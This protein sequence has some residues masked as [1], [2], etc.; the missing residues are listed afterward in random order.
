MF[1][2]PQTV[3]WSMQRLHC[4]T[5]RA[6]CGLAISV[7]LSLSSAQAAES[8]E[9]LSQVRFQTTYVW[10]RKPG[11]S[12]AYSGENSLRPEL[13]K[14]SFTLTTT[15]FL[16]VRTWQ[17][18]EL[19]FN[20]EMS[21]S[22]ALSNLHGLG[23]LTNGENQKGSSPSPIFYVGRLFGR[24]TWNLGGGSDS[25]ESAPNQLAGPVDKHR[26]ILTAGKLSLTDI[27]DN[28]SFSH[29]P[30]TQFL[31][32]AIMTHG[33]FDYA[34]DQ[35][36]YTVGAALEYYR[37]DL[38]FRFGRFQ[39]PIESN[40]LALDSQ[41]MNHYG[42]QLEIER[43][44]E[45]GG[46]P[47]KFRLLAFRN[48]ASMGSFRDAIDYWNSQG[49]TGVPAVS[50]VR[51]NQIK[52]GYGASIEQNLSADAGIFLRAS[53]NDGGTEAYAF[54][55]IE[56]SI[57]GGLLVKGNLWGR[58]NDSAGVAF[59]INGLSSAH[60]DYLARGG[61]G[62]FIGDGNINYRPERILEV[63]HS[64]GVMK[65][66]WLSFDFQH[67]TNPAYNAD[68]GPVRIIGVRLHLKY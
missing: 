55:E 50:N 42:D 62:A 13:E 54:T 17:G 2:G 16:G 3:R 65:D 32:W 67:L 52:R 40:G 64:I 7:F 68:R 59:A 61:L 4:I 63:F 21:M 48:R 33:A 14:R 37:N 66:T 20:P 5:A 31:N 6:F 18:G 47:G 19:Y 44:Y 45:R 46:Q 34:A 23:G 12:A 22:Q 11:F 36:G 10:Q 30:R 29:D 25:L 56:R 57:S 9:D 35:R 49:K 51:K 39:Q 58:P 38:A 8:D 53:S 28:N 27:F 41:I 26:L 60:R 1:S 43:A 15:A 24:H